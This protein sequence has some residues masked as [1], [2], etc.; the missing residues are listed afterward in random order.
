MISLSA[1]LDVV[2]SAKRWRVFRWLRRYRPHF[3]DSANWLYGRENLEWMNDPTLRSQLP[4]SFRGLAALWRLQFSLGLATAVG[5]RL[6]FRVASWAYQRQSSDPVSLRVIGKTVYLNPRDPRMLTVPPEL[7]RLLQPGSV[8]EELLHEGDSF[9]DVGANHGAYSLSAASLVGRS[10]RVLSI[11]PQPALSL[12]VAQTFRAN[13]FSQ[14]S[15][16][17][18]ACGEAA[19]RADF[20]VPRASS[21]AAGFHKSYSA[22][23]KHDT[24]TVLQRPLDDIVRHFALTGSLIIKLD[25]EGHELSVLKGASNLIRARKPI[26]LMEINPEAMSAAGT[27]LSELKAMLRTLG[28]TGY[29]AIRSGHHNSIV[30]VETMASDHHQDVILYF[31]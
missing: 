14:S 3:G 11:E 29:R 7:A 8:L 6:A 21:G 18:F 5:G 16:L 17:P 24:I 9:I 23:K 10:G 22:L 25:V 30:D 27:N 19:G 20:F 2:T 26:V 12:L 31:E 28:C 1:A 4:W 13:G 15:V